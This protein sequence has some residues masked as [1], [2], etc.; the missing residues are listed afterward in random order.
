LVFNGTPMTFKGKTEMLSLQGDTMQISTGPV[1]AFVAIKHL[2]T[3]GGGFFGANSAH[4]FENP[5]YLTNITQ[6]A[7]QMLL[8]IALIFAMR[9]MLRR[10]K[11]AWMVFG[12]H[13]SWLPPTSL[14]NC[15]FRNERQSNF[16]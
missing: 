15:D 16:G 9:Y 1:A 11:L 5:N 13:E 3:N 2:G 7:S 8:P 6:M 14:A 10:R 4:P 12:R